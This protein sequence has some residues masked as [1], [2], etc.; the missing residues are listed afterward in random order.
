MAQRDGEKKKT[1]VRTHIASMLK[2]T[3]YVGLGNGTTT[4]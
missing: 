2:A 1:V 3:I 4:I